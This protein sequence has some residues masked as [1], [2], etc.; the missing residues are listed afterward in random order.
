[1]PEVGFVE[2]YKAEPSMSSLAVLGFKNE[3]RDSTPGTVTMKLPKVPSS[4]RPA[5]VV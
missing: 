1:M 3:Y 4:W 2:M 5:C